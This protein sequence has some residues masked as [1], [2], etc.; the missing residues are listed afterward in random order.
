MLVLIITSHPSQMNVQ[1]ELLHYPGF[2]IGSSTGVG[3][4]VGGTS[5]SGSDSVSKM[6]KFYVKVFL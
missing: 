5:V 1:E 4:S 3:G 6:L 2:G